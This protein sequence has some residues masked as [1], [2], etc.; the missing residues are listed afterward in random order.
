LVIPIEKSI[1]NS[2]FADKD[3]SSKRLYFERL[4]LLQMQKNGEGSLVR[5]R[6][7]GCGPADMGSNPIPCS[8]QFSLPRN[9][10]F[11]EPRI[12]D[13]SVEKKPGKES[14]FL[15]SYIYGGII[16]LW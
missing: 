2:A 7:A 11:P 6:M 9:R 4:R 15:N 5:S 12:S 16:K 1:K 3:R 8:F 10:R 13:S 14:I